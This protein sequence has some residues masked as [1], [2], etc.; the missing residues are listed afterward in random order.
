[1]DILNM[2]GRKEYSIQGVE[3]I[4]TNLTA[5]VNISDKTSRSLT[6]FLD[7][8]IQ[9]GQSARDIARDLY[10]N[11]D[12]YWTIYVINKMTN[13]V[14]DW[15]VSDADIYNRIVA[16]K[17]FEGVDAVYTYADSGG[18]QTDLYAVR[19]QNN[20]ADAVTDSSIVSSYN[21]TPVSRFEFDK[22]KNNAKRQIRLIDPDFIAEFVLRYREALK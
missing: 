3:Y 19:F 11:E 15:P 4:L 20:I 9:D 14:D 13:S 8:N 7:H 6:L 2:L 10:E 17:G 12:Y 21:M 22:M 18:N 1:M 5:N 16:E